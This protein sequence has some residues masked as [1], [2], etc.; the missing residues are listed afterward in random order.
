[1]RFRW[2]LL[3]A[4]TILVVGVAGQISYDFYFR[5]YVLAKKVLVAKSDIPQNKLITDDDLVYKSVPNELVPREAIV[6][7]ATVVGKAAIV[8]ITKGSPLTLTMVDVDNLHPKE[9]EVIFPVPKDALFAVNGSLRKRDLVDVSLFRE[10]VEYYEGTDEL[11]PHLPEPIIERVPVV[12][13]RTEDNQ[14][15][16]DTEQ[17]DTN[18]RETSTGRVSNVELLLTKEQRDMLIEKISEG[19]KIWITR[20]GS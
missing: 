14:S 20:V 13:V 9:G 5:P 4:L 16:K 19:Y 6:D 12:F 11:K 10:F 15:V 7:P 17:G 1:M 3:L 8:S 18:Q 2:Q